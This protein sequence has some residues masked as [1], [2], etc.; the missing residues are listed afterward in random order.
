MFVR[1]TNPR[2]HRQRLK[3]EQLERRCVLAALPL[4]SEFQFQNQETI[5][6]GDGNSSD[7]IEIH[8]AGDAAI[9]LAGYHLTDDPA[10]LDRWSF[11]ATMLGIGDY[12]L[13][14]ASGTGTPDTAGNLHTNF[15]LTADDDFLALVEPDGTTIASQ[16]GPALPEQ[17]TD[18]S[19]GVTQEEVVTHFVS[20]GD[21]G[22]L[23]VPTVTDDVAIG[24]T[25]NGATE[26]FDDTNWQ[27]VMLGIGFED[28]PPPTDLTN[29]A[30]AGVAVQSTDG[31]GLAANNAIDGNRVGGSIS[32]TN[33]GDLNPWWEV[34]LGNDVYL[35]TI[36]A[37]TRTGCCS[38]ER[39][40]N[41]TIEVRDASDNILYTSAVFNPWDGSGGA[42]P[43]LAHGTAFSVDLTSEPGGGVTG[44]KVRVSK[45]AHGGA[46][47]SE[48]LHLAEVEVFGRTIPPGPYH[49]W[50][51]TDV[52]S[53][54]KG[55][56]RD[57]LSTHNFR[58]GRCESLGDTHAEHAV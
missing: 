33:T 45:V 57:G 7:W 36:D 10:D 29:V 30:L 14:F 39:D 40:Y 6:D 49:D 55:R 38:P 56:Q 37:Y 9:D 48:W 18:I 15:E 21:A 4:I 24:S 27:P 42:A 41:I 34:D 51:T 5:L 31:F 8:N 22:S 1:Q 13:V 23:L 35:E 53:A 54:M 16:F 52:Q 50:I 20:A 2:R 28:D 46:G 47:H 17:L 11:P 12:L 44:R 58:R 32:H 43:A 25:W 26:P 19:Y 3:F